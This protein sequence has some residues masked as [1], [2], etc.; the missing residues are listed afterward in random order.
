MLKPLM[1]TLLW[2]VLAGAAPAVQALLDDVAWEAQRIV[3]VDG[4]SFETRVHHAPLR[5]R[6]RAVV[7]GVPIDM[8]LRYDRNL[9]WQLT[10]LFGLAGQTDIS[11]MD[12]P[13]NIR[14]LARERL[15]EETVAGGQRAVKHRLRFETRDGE[16]FEGFYWQNAAG[17]HVKS[18]FPVRDQ[19]GRLRQVELELREL[20][21][22]PQPDALFE[23]P[24]DYQVVPL[25]AGEIVRLILGP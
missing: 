14:V 12:S 2:W 17:V 1:I 20:R 11:A 10:P 21:V 6:I 5:E 9:M 16:S 22:A 24:A 19:D 23:L 25:D 3:R 15:G 8:I 4:R 13:A 18:L 7:K